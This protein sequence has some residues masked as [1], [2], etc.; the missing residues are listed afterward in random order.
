MKVYLL[1]L[2]CL[3][4][5]FP[6]F[7]QNPRILDSLFAKTESGNQ[8]EQ[9]DAY[10]DIAR[11]YRQ[12]NADS[13]NWYAQIAIQRA[14]SLNYPEGKI[15]AYYE[16]GFAAD[17][18]GDY[19]RAVQLFNNVI[20][21]SDSI[22]YTI[23][24]TKGYNGL[25]LVYEM[26]GDYVKALHYH[27]LNLEILEK[28]NDR[29][30][31]AMVY[32]NIAIVYKD[33]KEY[34]KSL[35]SHWKS[36][37]ISEETFDSLGMAISNYNIGHTN[38]LKGNNEQAL[39]HF[40]KTKEITELTNDI[41]GMGKVYHSIGD[42]YYSDKLYKKAFDYYSK[43]KA[44]YEEC[45]ANTDLT[46]PLIGLGKIYLHDSNHNQ[47]QQYLSKALSL[48]Q[49]TGH[50]VNIRNSS[51][52]LFQSSKQMGDYQRA[53]DYYVLFNTMK[54]S[55]LNDEQI[56]RLTLL[57]AEYNFKK[58]RDSIN[59][60]NEK[61][62]MTL[63]QQ[64]ER[65][66]NTQNVSIIG[67]VILI[68]VLIILYRY[69]QLKK[70]A[71]LELQLL[72][73]KIQDRNASLS[74]LN[75]EKN[76]LIGI[77]A[78]DL[79]NPLSNIVGAAGVLKTSE[80][81]EEKLKFLDVIHT[82][83]RKLMNM[84]SEIL[85]VESIEQRVADLDLSNINLTEVVN[86]V[87][88][89]F[90][91]QAKAKQVQLVPHITENV[92]INAH[93]IYVPQVI[94]NLLSNAIKFSPSEKNVFINLSINQSQAL[95][96]VRDEGPGLDKEDKARLFQKY[97]RLSAEPTAGEDSTGLGLSIV[98]KFVDAMKGKIWV[99]T[100]VGKGASFFVAFELA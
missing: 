86:D 66:Q 59:Y 15:D 100:E 64:I 93:A 27:L 16:I 84:I 52:L 83:G 25:G 61:A 44:F 20:T 53:L 71:H 89:Q 6:L 37:K 24:L 13:T 87:I 80:K 69:Y 17:R 42:I 26:Q 5:A 22:N 49:K 32:N 46:D 81:D 33:Q 70:H 43:S 63:D 99:E 88:D 54:D 67:M 50:I 82:S 7:A 91:E 28:L 12:I 34:D 3:F 8:R 4:S 35:E 72:N 47:A 90:D 92:H 1:L 51:E 65:Q 79:K 98:K 2:V 76:N 14:E 97:Q 58:E 60:A 21:Q 38:Q 62:R 95:M 41:Y 10:V 31:M 30:G 11:E 68:G 77:V 74:N 48:A 45:T 56:K 75:A 96:E 36:L 18:T 85:N 29:R 9:V 55:T 78:H 23:G 40:L 39:F 57:E 94:E 73:A 19:A